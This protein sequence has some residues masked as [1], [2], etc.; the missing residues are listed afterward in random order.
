MAN[1]GLLVKMMNKFL[2]FRCFFFSTSTERNVGEVGDILESRFKGMNFN[3]D[4]K[5]QE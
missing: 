5:C 2:K 4:E 1:C 3:L